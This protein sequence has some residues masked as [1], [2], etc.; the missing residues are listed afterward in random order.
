M[1]RGVACEQDAAS[2]NMLPI[3]FALLGEG[4]TS[5]LGAVTRS[6]HRDAGPCSVEL[7]ITAFL[8]DHGILGR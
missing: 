2:E 5:V 1:L 6:V 8:G 3:I 7:M 4:R